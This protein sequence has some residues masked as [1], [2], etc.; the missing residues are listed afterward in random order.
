MGAR[1][2]FDVAILASTDT[3]MLPVLE[4]L[5]GLNLDL[6]CEVVAWAG[7]SQKLALPGQTIPVRWISPRDFHTIADTTHY[8]PS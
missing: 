1:G 6:E 8:S 3:D 5:L 2:E 4:G 7:L